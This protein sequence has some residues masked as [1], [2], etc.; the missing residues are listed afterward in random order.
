MSASSKA[1][2]S[3]KSINNFLGGSVQVMKCLQ[4]ELIQF[5]GSWAEDGS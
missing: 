4:H 3:P 1:P 2:S 5:K